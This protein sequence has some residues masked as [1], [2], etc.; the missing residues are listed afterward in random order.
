[1]L[2]A[3]AAAADTTVAVAAD[4]TV[5]NITLCHC[6]LS[7]TC[8]FSLL[9]MVSA[10]AAPPSSSPSSPLSSPSLSYQPHDHVQPLVPP[11]VHAREARA[12]VHVHTLPAQHQSA[13]PTLI[14]CSCHVDYLIARFIAH[15]AHFCFALRTATIAA[16]TATTITAITTTTTITPPTTVVFIV[17]GSAALDAHQLALAG[18]TIAEIATTTTTTAAATL[19]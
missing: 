15:A 3:A 10:F 6:E 18:R 11:R 5:S 19:G 16:I 4:E 9:L 8:W 1:V 12:T 2:P 14:V 7:F 13:F 17:L